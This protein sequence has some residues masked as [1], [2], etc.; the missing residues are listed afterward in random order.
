LETD[1]D[2]ATTEVVDEVDANNNASVQ[3]DK[4]KPL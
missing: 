3:G 1:L 4:K 2:T